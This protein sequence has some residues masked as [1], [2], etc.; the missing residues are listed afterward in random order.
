M[1]AIISGRAGVALLIE[2]EACFSFDVENPAALAPRRHT[3]LRLLFGEAPDL[4]FFEG[5]NREE[6]TR[7]LRLAFDR[8]AALDLVL[9]LLDP[10]LSVGVRDAAAAELERLISGHEPVRAYLEDILYGKPLPAACDLDSAVA[11]CRELGQTPELLFV[12]LQLGF[13]QSTIQHVWRAWEGVPAEA[14]GGEERRLE[15]HQAF[16]QAG[17]FSRYVKSLAGDLPVTAPDG[18]L[19]DLS[20]ARETL[21]RWMLNLSAVAE[22]EPAD[23]YADGH[24]N[25]ESGISIPPPL[26]QPA[27]VYA[28]GLGIAAQVRAAANGSQDALR[29]LFKTYGEI[30]ESAVRRTLISRGCFDPDNHAD[31]AEVDAW[32]R[33]L[34]GYE[35]APE[36]F[37][38]DFTEWIKLRSILA[39]TIHASRCEKVPR[40]ARRYRRHEGAGDL[41]GRVEALRE[42]GYSFPAIGALLGI[43]AAQVREVYNSRPLHEQNRERAA[44]AQGKLKLSR[45]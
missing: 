31:E 36:E 30:V 11:R 38:K 22:G 41:F 25:E 24:S 4:E 28:A 6:A 19:P 14:F 42:Q 43:D 27:P 20:G 16:A 32:E 44:A 39:A 29:W 26:N 17:L 35:T 23:E 12:L 15:L 40:Y 8:G 34:L 18:P 9:I 1:D 7:H 33:I 10:E 5:V 3:D 2:G 45:R 13:R 37:E 21:E